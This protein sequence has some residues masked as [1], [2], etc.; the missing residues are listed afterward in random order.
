MSM[1]SHPEGQHRL[2]AHLCRGCSSS[3]KTSHKHLLCA[4]V[5]QLLAMCHLIVPYDSPVRE[6]Q[7]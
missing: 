2:Q 3:F 4:S 1:N 7:S 5:C 6:G